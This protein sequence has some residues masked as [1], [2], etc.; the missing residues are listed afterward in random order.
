MRECMDLEF[1]EPTTSNE[2]YLADYKEKFI[3]QYRA[4]RQ[5][6]IQQN[7]PLQDFVNGEFHNAT[8]MREASKNLR[9]MGLDSDYKSLLRLIPSDSAD[10][11]IEIMAEVRAYYQ[12]EQASSRGNTSNIHQSPSS[13]LSIISR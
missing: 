6:Q 5:V 1:E 12:G 8:V 2:H 9:A 4:A 10:H 7:T 11:A 13:D 3:A